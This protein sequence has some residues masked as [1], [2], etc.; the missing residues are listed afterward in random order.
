MNQP[1]ISYSYKK[2]Y[3]ILLVLI[4]LT[5]LGLIVEGEAWGEWDIS[6]WQV[7]DSWREVAQRLS[8]IWSAPLPDYNLPGW[9]EGILPYLGYIISGFIGVLLLFIL[10]YCIGLLITRKK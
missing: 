8:S 1:T 7:P 2:V 4:L 3:I 10:N 5:P 6:Q 9:N